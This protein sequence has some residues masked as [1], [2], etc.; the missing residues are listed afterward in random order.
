MERFA[1]EIYSAAVIA[2]QQNVLSLGRLMSP[3]DITAAMQSRSE[4]EKEAIKGWHVCGEMHPDMWKLACG[5][6]ELLKTRLQ[7]MA[8]T[9]GVGCAYAFIFQEI[10]DWQHRF[11]IPLAGPSVRGFVDALGSEAISISMA[12]RE[13]DHAIVRSLFI[14]DAARKDIQASFQHDWQDP[15]GQLQDASMLSLRLMLPEFVGPIAAPAIKSACVTL[16]V[17]DDIR[18]LSKKMEQRYM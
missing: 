16:V 2:V 6:H 12:N 8:P 18:E 11:V 3:K 15:V 17:P 4:N 13:N 9:D 5:R 10:D 1:T 7:I 14:P